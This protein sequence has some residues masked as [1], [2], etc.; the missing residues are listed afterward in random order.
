MYKIGFEECIEP[1]MMILGEVKVDEV[2]N[3]IHSK[4]RTRR[5]EVVL[6]FSS[7]SN[8]SWKS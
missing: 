2:N 1:C 4:N 3:R 7:A 5:S 8:L 6:R